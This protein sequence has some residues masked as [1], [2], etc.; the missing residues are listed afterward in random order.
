[1][2]EDYAIFIE[3]P[4]LQLRGRQIVFFIW[5]GLAMP[6]LIDQAARE[7]ALTRW[8][9]PECLHVPIAAV[10][11]AVITTYVGG[12]QRVLADGSPRKAFVVRIKEPPSADLRLPI[13]DLEAS[14]VFHSRL[15]VWVHIAFTRYRI[16]YRA[17]FPTESIDRM[18]LSHA[19]NRRV[20]ALKGF[21]YVRITPTSRRNNSSSAFSENWGVA[22]HGTPEQMAA[23]RR[24]GAFIQFADLSDLMLMLDLQLGGGVMAAVNEGQQLVRPRAAVR[25][26]S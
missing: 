15:Q 14:R 11:E 18:V 1:V 19:M 2:F 7:I 21:S 13:W 10:D 16:A 22:L 4:R 17:A 26:E 24:R 3:I 12:I 5:Q 25:P 6:F 8:A 23:N 9:L 20:A